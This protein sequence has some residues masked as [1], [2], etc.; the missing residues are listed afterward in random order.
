M[1]LISTIVIIVLFQF[2][3]IISVA[4]FPEGIKDPG[5]IKSVASAAYGTDVIIQPNSGEDQSGVR[6]SCAFNG[7]LYSSFM[8]SSGGFRVARS[9]DNGLSWT[10][11]I[12]LRSDLYLVAMDLAVTGT[13]PGSLKVWVVNS[14]YTKSNID[15]WEVSVEELNGD[16]AMTGTTLL[17]QILSNSGFPGVAIASDYKYPSTGTNPFSIGVLYSKAGNARD[18][19]IFRSSGDGGITF[20]NH[21]AVA[22]MQSYLGGKVSLAFGRSPGQPEGR[23]FAAWAEAP[24][25][26]PAGQIYTAYTEASYNSNWTA[27]YRVDNIPQ[28]AANTSRNPV[29]ACQANNMNNGSMEFTSMILFDRFDQT[30]GKYGIAGVYNTSPVSAGI[31]QP[32][33]VSG[34]SASWDIQPDI[35]FDPDHNNFY[36]TWCDSTGQKLNC[37]Y[38]AMDI[39]APDSWTPFSEAYNDQPNLLAP[40]PRVAVNLA[41]QQIVNVWTGKVNEMIGNATFDGGDMFVATPEITGIGH[42]FEVSVSPNPSASLITIS[43]QLEAPADVK[44]V[45]YNLFGQ[46]LLTLPETRFE[47]GKQSMQLNVAKL[48]SGSYIYQVIYG[49]QLSSGRISV[50]R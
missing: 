25:W 34:T 5:P 50:I 15:I 3:A 45:L 39:P 2:V 24:Y 1:K 36:A 47:K 38:Q 10:Y 29:I 11:S 32:T 4:Q 19:I 21:K 48:V 27:P 42:S 6:I 20:D 49:S 41:V 26:D 28:N 23:Y 46:Q 9:T 22:G 7:W 40:F 43:F 8:I 18:S 17:D 44:F 13:D 30:T 33:L 16:L 37:S 14:G 12:T 31:W 35:T